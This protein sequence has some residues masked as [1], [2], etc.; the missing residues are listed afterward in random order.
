MSASLPVFPIDQRAYERGL[1][2]VHCGLCLAACP[3]YIQTG[4]EA[5]SPRGRIQ[6]IRGL[7]EGK[8]ESSDSTRHHLDLCLDCRACETA[9]PSGVVYHELIEEYRIQAARRFPL[10]L[11]ARVLRWLNFNIVTRPARLKLAMIPL[12]LLGVRFLPRGKIRP[13]KLAAMPDGTPSVGF[14]TGCVS[15]VLFAPVNQKA[16]ELLNACGAGVALP[17]A[18]V[19]CGAIH[20]HNGDLAGAQALARRN[21]DA[22]GSDGQFIVTTAAGCGAMLKEYDLLLRDD[23]AYAQKAREFCA[24]VRD[25]T[26][27]LADLKLP[28]LGHRLELTA[29]YHDACHLAH[30]QKVTAAPRKLLGQIPGLKLIPLAESDQ[31]CGAAG[32]Y[33]LTQP[34][35]AGRLADRKLGNIASTG[36]SVCVSANAGCTLHLRR[37]AANAGKS[38]TIVHPVELL[39]AAAF[40]DG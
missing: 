3:T 28:P 5:D 23:P 8:I 20:Y 19:C 34:E 31:C 12:R 25:V 7:A 24:R 16:A 21:I 2:C 33:F 30:G 15:S 11:R 26:E 10:S 1:A 4:H 37:R 22:F 27:L 17:G 9:C 36:A 29:T 14:H 39:H 38:V 32:T 40:G 18:Q 35:M 6:L 13:R